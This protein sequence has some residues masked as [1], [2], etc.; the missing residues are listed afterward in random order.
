MIFVDWIT[1]KVIGGSLKLMG[2]EGI[3]FLYLNFCG[4]VVV[5]GCGSG[6][7]GFKVFG[8]GGGGSCGF[9]W[10]K[11]D[12][13]GG[14]GSRGSGGLNCSASTGFIGFST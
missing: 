13:R 9:G 5:N 3:D 7:D 8:S 10:I 1:S 2:R 12:T 6:G 4:E 14:G 11:V